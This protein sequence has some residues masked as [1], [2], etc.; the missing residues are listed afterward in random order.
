MRAPPSVARREG[1]G[2]IR[3]GIRAATVGSAVRE[4]SARH[5]G[6]KERN[7]KSRRGEERNDGET[8]EWMD[9]HAMAYAVRP[10]ISLTCCH[11]K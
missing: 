11:S 9:S 10:L 1:G 2:K 3:T 7:G 6:N 4:S 5:D 8:G